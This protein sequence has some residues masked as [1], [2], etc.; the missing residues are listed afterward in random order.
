VLGGAL[1]GVSASAGYLSLASAT[2][3]PSEPDWSGAEEVSEVVAS[4]WS[5]PELTHVVGSTQSGALEQA[6]PA[7]TTI[8][9][10]ASRNTNFDAR[11]SPDIRVT[12]NTAR[13]HASPTAFPIQAMTC[14]SKRGALARLAAVHNA[15][16]LARQMESRSK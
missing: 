6:L 15:A 3:L 14:P 16:Y 1:S 12:P 5:G 8:A 4:G 7:P 11:A 13:E 10:T 9:S 2:V